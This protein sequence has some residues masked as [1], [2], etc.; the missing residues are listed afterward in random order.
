VASRRGDVLISGA[1]VAGPTLAFW[2]HRFG[3]RPVVVERSPALS[4]GW[5]GHAVDLFGAA[6]DVAERM[7][8]LP[9]V[10]EARTRTE[11]ISLVR[12]GKRPVNI[13]FS[14]LVA[15]IA[16]RHV[17]LMRGE[18]AGILHEATRHEVE[19]VFG[20]SIRS[21]TQTDHGVEV[22]F[23]HGTARRF[24]LVVGADGLHSLVRRLT[25]GDEARFR[26]YLGGYL[27]VYTVPNRLQLHRRMLTYLTPGRLAATYPVWQTGQA[28][29]AFLFRRAREFDIHHRDIDGQKRALR[30][31]YAD[32]GGEIPRLLAELDQADD[33]Y[34]DSISQIAMGRWSH[35]RVTLVGDA[36]YSPGPAVGG[37]TSLAVVGAYLLAAAL[38][39]AGRD[40]VRAFNRYQD[41]MREPVA[42]SRQIGPVTMKSLIP[43]T[44]RQVWLT[45]ES[46]RIIPRLPAAV[47]RR[48]FAF[49]GTPAT[50]LESVTI[51]NQA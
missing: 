42:R 14:R 4:R 31:V 34:F 7:G 36:G 16:D 25:F 37:G 24:D 35:G 15:G 21:L 46:M 30:D 32:Y 45:I 2:L 8:V 47:G 38:R 12:P 6:V 10:L 5:G 41:A 43:A 11:L 20:D 13:D 28:R 1:S 51:N 33:F 50:A 40:H 19:Y 26:R 23:D 18:L 27:A 49:Q 48:L 22:T 3:W 39:E 9:E 44:R 17:E 29:A